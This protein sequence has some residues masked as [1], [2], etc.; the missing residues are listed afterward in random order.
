MIETINSR[1]KSV[2][3]DC[4]IRKHEFDQNDDNQIFLYL[5]RRNMQENGAR[6]VDSFPLRIPPKG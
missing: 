1:I 5:M 6:R 4:R 3:I 2:V